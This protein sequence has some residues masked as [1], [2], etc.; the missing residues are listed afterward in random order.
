LDVRYQLIKLHLRGESLNARKGAAIATTSLDRKSRLVSATF[1]VLAPLLL[2]F[3]IYA[4]KALATSWSEMVLHSFDRTDGEH[5]TAALIQG[6][7]GNFYGTTNNGGANYLFAEGAGTVFQ[8]TPSGSLT[9]LYSFCSVVTLGTGYCLDGVGPFAGLIQGTD[10]NF[11][12]TTAGGGAIPYPTDS[13]GY[14]TV[15]KLAVSG[16]PP[17]ATLTTLYS[18]CSQANCTDGEL[19]NGGVIEGSDG[20]FYGTTGSGGT[21]GD[22]TMFRLTPSTTPGGSTLTTLYSFC[23]VVDPRTNYCL[24]GDTPSAVIQGNDGNFYGITY[25]GGAKDD[26]TV[27]KLTPSGQL[28]TLHSFCTKHGPGKRCFD[29]QNP[30]GVIQGSDGNLYG[31]T[32]LGGKIKYGTVF[33]LAPSGKLATLYS[34]CRKAGCADGKF[35][36]GRLIQGSD[37]NFY[38]TTEGGGAGTKPLDYGTVFKITPSGKL[39]TL[40]SFCSID[41]PGASICFDGWGPVGGLLQSNNGNFYGTATFGGANADG[42]LF[43]LSPTPK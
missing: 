28:T 42:T 3:A 7:D 31:T 5:P 17:T 13:I 15:F 21:N 37:G 40:Y 32:G 30:T 14:G 9:T 8:L 34:F 6:T 4:P 43:E 29:G 25:G 20:N 2:S 1:V 10:G 11:Y 19:P 35:P 41:E 38:G 23:S 22:G 26:G 39:T 16:T 12:G 24:D 36:D 27:F 33:K 18:F